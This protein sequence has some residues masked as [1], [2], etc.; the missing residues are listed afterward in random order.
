L[1]TFKA[2]GVV[3]MSGV[4]EKLLS[5]AMK[6]SAEDREI[7]A[8]QLLLSIDGST[9]TQVDAAWADEVERRLDALDRGETKAIPLDEAMNQIRQS[10]G[11]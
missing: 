10:L 11:K 9:R 2:I 5:E 7:L 6:L 3:T 1:A 4:A 8:E